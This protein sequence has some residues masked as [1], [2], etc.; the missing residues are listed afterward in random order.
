M[1]GTE[2]SCMM[3]L[4]ISRRKKWRRIIP[5]INTYSGTCLF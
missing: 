4:R 2:A 1:S 5:A 3:I